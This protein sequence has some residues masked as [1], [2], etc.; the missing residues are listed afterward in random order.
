M[1]GRLQL[2]QGARGVF[3]EL[4]EVESQSFEL[5]SRKAVDEMLDGKA[6]AGAGLAEDGD[7]ERT[8]FV[9]V[10]QI[11]VDQRADGVDALDLFPVDGDVV[12]VL[13]PRRRIKGLGDAVADDAH[14]DGIHVLEAGTGDIAQKVGVVPGRTGAPAGTGAAAGRRRLAS[15]SCGRVLA[16][17]TAAALRIG[18]KVRER[19]I[20]PRFRRRVARRLRIARQ[21]AVP[22]P[23]V[24]GEQFAFLFDRAGFEIVA[25]CGQA[26]AQRDEQRN[27]FR[28]E[29]V[30]QQPARQQT[31]GAEHSAFVAG[32][33]SPFRLLRQVQEPLQHHA[34]VVLAPLLPVV[35]RLHAQPAA[36]QASRGAAT[37]KEDADPAAECQVV[38]GRAALEFPHEFLNRAIP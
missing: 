10:Q 4:G 28:I 31:G 7:G 25:D 27:L 13:R 16:E 15:F 18:R 8:P 17:R 14:G 6:L 24:I 36:A 19:R 12:S 30:S 9:I 35:L 3:G 32:V 11:G 38:C 34:V 20:A 1:Q 37:T 33:E 21:D 29:F 26:A 5:P 22:Q 23:D 2:L